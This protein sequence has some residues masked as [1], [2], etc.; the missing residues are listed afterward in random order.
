MKPTPLDLIAK[1]ADFFFGKLMT[2]LFLVYFDTHNNKIH[3]IYK[4]TSVF[5]F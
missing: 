4:Q 2:I 5:W 1:G 3:T